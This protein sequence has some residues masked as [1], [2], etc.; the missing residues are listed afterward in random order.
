MATYAIGDVQGCF[1]E[2]RALLDL[3]AFDPS[4]D[5]LWLVGDLV[6]RG[7][8]SL[9]VLRFARGLGESALAVL[10][11]HDFHLLNV[12]AGNVHPHR[13][14]TLQ[15]VLEAP[16]RDEL[17]DWLARR[18]LV[19]REGDWLMVHAG[20]LP[21]WTAQRAVELSA[22]VE[23]SLSGASRRDFLRHLYGNEP[24]R[25]SESLQGWDRLRVIVNACTRLRFIAADG[26]MEFREKRGPEHTP[27]G[28][29]PWFEV[30]G[31]AWP[32]VSVVCGHWS[33]LDLY[34]TEE[35][36]MLDTGCV[37]GRSLSAMRLEDRRLFQVKSGMA[38]VPKPGA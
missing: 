30:P 36:V 29:L 32:G 3:V 23:A 22:E 35:V 17:L 12:A 1:A 18:P 25:W 27:P 15:A 38:P 4:R 6:N 14:D 11:N 34:A 7:P 24:A 19:V 5:R 20:L 16:D 10:G 13:H 8:A 21:T 9:E 28:F 26:R 33:T 2:L 31:R 37:W